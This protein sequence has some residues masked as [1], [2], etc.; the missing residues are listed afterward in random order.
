ML[1]NDKKFINCI[2]HYHN[3]ASDTDLIWFPFKFL[4]PLKNEE[5][6]VALTLKLTLCFTLYTFLLYVIKVWITSQSFHPHDSLMF[7]LFTCCAFFIHFN[8]VTRFFWNR[9]A[10]K[11]HSNGENTQ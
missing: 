1:N 9:R 5:I 11:I 10:K 6:T 2:Q 4:R 8:T 3:K 7:F